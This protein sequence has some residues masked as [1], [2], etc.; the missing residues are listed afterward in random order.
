MPELPE[1]E[2]VTQSVRKHL[3][4]QKFSS[5]SVIWGKTLDNFTS[6]DF[7]NKVRGKPI[8]DVYRRAKYIIIDLNDEL[9]STKPTL[10]EHYTRV[11]ETSY[12]KIM[13]CG[14]GPLDTMVSMESIMKFEKFNDISAIKVG[15]KFL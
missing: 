5:I 3:V 6:D 15:E 9:N 7:D 10:D 4:K 13:S 11:P 14:L 8:K 1:V 12:F 2:T